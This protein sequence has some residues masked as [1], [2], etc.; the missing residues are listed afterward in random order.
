MENLITDVHVLLTTINNSPFP[1][2]KSILLSIMGESKAKSSYK[3]QKVGLS[4][5]T[6]EIIENGPAKFLHLP[7]SYFN[8]C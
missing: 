3:V 5:S 4:K 8:S 2:E 7:E 6:V 1:E